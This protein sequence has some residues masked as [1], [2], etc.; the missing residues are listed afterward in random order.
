MIKLTLANKKQVEKLR[1][2]F[3]G[4]T[5]AGLNL[6]EQNS[7]FEDLT[8]KSKGKSKVVV[9]LLSDVT[10]PSLRRRKCR[11]I[12]RNL[13]FLATEENVL[14]KLISFGPITEVNIPKVELKHDKNEAVNEKGSMASPDSVVE[15]H[16]LRSRGFAFVTFLCEKVL[17]MIRS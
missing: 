4:K 5:V 10:D 17:F 1:N 13:S 8:M 16:K 15:N 7:N 6:L 11:V 9:R 14:S 2:G 3:D 12:V